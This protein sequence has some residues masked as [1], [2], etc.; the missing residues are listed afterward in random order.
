MIRE[1]LPEAPETTRVLSGLEFLDTREALASFKQQN[2]NIRFVSR[3][4]KL[5]WQRYLEGEDPIIR[6][7]ERE[8]KWRNSAVGE[9]L[10]STVTAGRQVLEI[11]SLSR[12]P[13]PF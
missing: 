11:G 1:M 2:M 9:G 3:E 6:G 4:N 5:R 7:P 12:S 8:P 10:G 13:A